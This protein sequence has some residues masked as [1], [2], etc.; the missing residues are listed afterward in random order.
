VLAGPALRALRAAAPRARIELL[1]SSAGAPAADLLPEVDSTVV[2]QVSWQQIDPNAGP[3]D[4]GLVRTLARRDY[5]AAIVLTSFSQSPWPAGY[6]CQRA[7]I[8]VRAGT[9]KEFGGTALTHWVPAPDDDLHQVDR[10][11]AVLDRL[12]VPPLGRALHAAV[13][14]AGR[15]AA[16]WALADAGADPDVAP[17]VL[18]PGASC[19][20][21]R[22]PPERFRE[23][24]RTLTGLGQ[25]VVVCGA[26]A[27]RELVA[28]VVDG[29]P[30]AV[31]LAGVLDVQGLAGLLSGAAAAVVNNSGGMHLA[32]AVG[33]PVV[34]LFAGTE[35]PEQYRPRS[36]PAVVLGVPTPCRPCRQFTCPFAG[37]CLDVAPVEVADAVA[38]LLRG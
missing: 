18:L 2:A 29:V 32:D 16:R 28:A 8:P 13:P 12:G 36:A 7:G 10:A 30:D 3:P 5:D 6:V 31:P 22:Y 1:A 37:E 26:P 20:S 33:T 24:A 25:P 9:S 11:L 19:P 35:L 21:R 38:R 23:V 17:V 14:A 27:E 15:A 4:D 34:A